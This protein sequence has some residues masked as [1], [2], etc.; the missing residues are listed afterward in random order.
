MAVL[1]EGVPVEYPPLGVQ[2]LL[3]PGSILRGASGV[4]H[5]AHAYLAQKLV[6]DPRG[7]LEL[8]GRV[9]PM[10]EP[11][12][13]DKRADALVELR[14]LNLQV[15]ESEHAVVGCCAAPGQALHGRVGAVDQLEKRVQPEQ[16]R[17]LYRD[18]GHLLCIQLERVDV[19][20]RAG[21]GEAR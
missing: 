10:P 19:Q 12:P 18:F 14:L 8:R 15:L 6:H 1:I 2:E 17:A 3:G 16:R 7:L 11:A 20:D 13:V 9:Q 21:V 5:R 4:L